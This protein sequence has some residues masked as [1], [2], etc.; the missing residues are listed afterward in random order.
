M[1]N[2]YDHLRRFV[3]RVTGP[4]QPPAESRRRRVRP[5]VEALEERQVPSSLPP[6]SFLLTLPPGTNFPAGG[7][8]VLS[9]NESTGPAFRRYLHDLGGGEVIHGHLD[10]AGIGIGEDIPVKLKEDGHEIRIVLEQGFTTTGRG[11]ELVGTIF[12]PEH[13]HHHHHHPGINYGFGGGG[14]SYGGG[15]RSFQ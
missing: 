7:V 4:P 8:I 9:E 3:A 1:L 15:G 14:G 11:G 12:P 6:L 13:H 10:L 2:W 5:K